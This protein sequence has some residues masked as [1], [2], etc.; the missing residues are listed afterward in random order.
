ML[1]D[2]QGHRSQAAEYAR[3]ADAATSSEKREH[4]QRLARAS[5]AMAHNAEWIKSTDEFL[6][7]WRPH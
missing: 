5:L 6:R 7:T 4:F 1:W 3:L 2:I